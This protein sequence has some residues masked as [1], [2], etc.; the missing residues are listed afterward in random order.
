MAFV[1][2]V[3]SSDDGTLFRSAS[4][5]AGASKLNRFLIHS[6]YIDDEV[7]YIIKSKCVGVYD[8]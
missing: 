6:A 2:A 1:G 8:V 4:V 5:M 7:Y 3:H